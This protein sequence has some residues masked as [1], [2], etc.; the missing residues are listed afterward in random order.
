MRDR[1]HY[2]VLAG[3]FDYPEHGYAK[4][5]DMAL[6]ILQ[7]KYPRLVHHLAGFAEVFPRLPLPV[8][9]EI[10]MRS[11]DVQSMT[12]LDIGY[13]MFGDDYKRGEI[14]VNLNREHRKYDNDCGS[15][16]AD[17]LPNILRLFA[18]L[19]EEELVSEMAHEI[20][21]PALRKMIA[22][23]DPARIAQK[24]NSY[25]KHYKTLI[26]TPGE[27]IALYSAPLKTLYQ[28]LKAD[29]NIRAE[30]ISKTSNDFLQS[31]VSEMSIENK[32]ETKGFI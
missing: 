28:V 19:E 4:K 16:L 22:E 13:V 25:K 20:L 9:E 27:G 10:Y 2:T 1:S 31:V 17:H 3:L 12:T 15:E 6:A 7:D 11:F 21:G 24:E 14:L 26:E 23:F 8:R 29:F 18:K 30:E 32:N 5:V